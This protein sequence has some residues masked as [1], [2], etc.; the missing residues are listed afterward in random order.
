[1]SKEDFKILSARD[2]V[3]MRTGMYLGSTALE[4][5]GRFVLGI[6]REVS[7]VPALL[8]MVD[9]ILDNSIDEAIRTEFKHANEISVNVQRTNVT[10]SDNGRGIPH[11]EIT[12]TETGEKMLRPVAAWT[13]VRAGT[14]FD[15]DRVTIGANGVGSACVNFMSKRFIGETWQ[16][17]RLVKIESVNGAET[18]DIEN[19]KYAR[20]GSGTSVQFYPDFKLLGVDNFEEGDHIELIHDRLNSLQIAF[21]EIKFKINGKL[22]KATNMRQYAAL[23]AGEGSAITQQ[24]DDRCAGHRQQ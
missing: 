8:K 17:K 21:P 9:E 6:W 4:Q 22:V 19:G 10:V 7:F 2:H 3:R 12:D 5:Q 15:D 18:T 14:S 13:R 11:D 24:R 16:A 1:M 23:F 20:S